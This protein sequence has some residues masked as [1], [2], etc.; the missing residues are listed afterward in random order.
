MAQWDEYSEK[1]TPEDGDTLMLKDSSD[2]YQSVKRLSFGNLK[3]WIIRKL[4]SEQFPQLKTEDKTVIGAINEIVQ[5]NINRETEL[6]EQLAQI[7]ETLKNVIS[8]D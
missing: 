8:T 2:T 7:K 5:D 6:E 1:K 3:Q 4:T